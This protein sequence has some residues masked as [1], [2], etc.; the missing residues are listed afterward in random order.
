M[1][2]GKPVYVALAQRKDVRK[3]QLESQLSAAA[4]RPGA[5]A[6]GRQ[7][8]PLQGAARKNNGGTGGGDIV[9]LCVRSLTLSLP[10]SR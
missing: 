4:V 10:L 5:M 3:A 2:K 8:G 6:G 7:P 9:R 1:L